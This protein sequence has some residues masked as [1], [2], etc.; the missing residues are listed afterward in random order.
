MPTASD[1]HL[2]A[3]NVRSG[4]VD[5]GGKPYIRHVNRVAAA[6]DA[7]ARHARLTDGRKVNLAA[8]LQAAYLHDV[9][10]DTEATADALRQAGFAESVV[11]MVELLTKTGET[12]SYA[13]RISALIQ[14]GNSARSL[15]KSSTTRITPTRP[16]LCRPAARPLE[17]AYPLTAYVRQLNVMKPSRRLRVTACAP[18]RDGEGRGGLSIYSSVECSGAVKGGY[19][20]RQP[21]RGQ[22][23]IQPHPHT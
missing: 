21:D 4:Q 15:S 23:R 22:Q 10:E 3:A 2:F 5:Q 8:I 1:G 7:R 14:S 11:T 13:E 12:L 18:Q 19:Q 6:A 17:A 16:E 20:D 9:L